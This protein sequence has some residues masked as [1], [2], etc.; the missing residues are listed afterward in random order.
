[1]LWHFSLGHPS[2][3]YLKKLFPSLVKHKNPL[4]LGCQS[5]QLSSCLFP[6]QPYMESKPF[7]IVHND[8]WDLQE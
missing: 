4:L 1:M 2:F 5:S 3:E 6:L 7:S 8:I